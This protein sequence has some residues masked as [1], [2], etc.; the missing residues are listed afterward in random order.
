MSRQHER[1]DLNLLQV[2]DAVMQDRNV[3]RAAERLA[4]TQPAVS[5]TLSRLRHV[6]KDELFVRTP[7]GV[8]PTRRA[9][10]IWPDVTEALSTLRRVVRPGS[11][12]P[13]QTAFTM[14]VALSDSLSLWLLPRLIASMQTLAPRLLIRA[15]PLAPA[16][17]EQRLV[18]GTLDL[19][20]GVFPAVQPPLRSRVAWSDRYICVMRE[21]HP[22][23]RAPFTREV[24]DQCRWLSLSFDGQSIGHADELLSRIGVTRTVSA[25]VNQF[26]AASEVLAW[27]DL[28]ALL[29]KLYADRFGKRTDMVTREPPYSLGEFQMS[30]AWH[31]RMQAQPRHRWF[32]ELVADEIRAAT[33]AETT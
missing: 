17:T 9:E 4:M 25:V 10:E 23:T 31:E 27:T 1:L 26:A 16:V 6:L 8:R 13:M 15:V 32:R 20:I 11:F 21:D 5:H 30:L 7:S 2:F 24:A 28:V 14:D 18:A 12:D 19:A 33:E 3:T 29:P 22:A